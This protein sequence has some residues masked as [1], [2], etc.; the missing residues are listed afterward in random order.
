MTC[1]LEE[2][3][4][5]IVMHCAWKV[6]RG[7]SRLLVV[8]N[9]TDTVAR[10]LR[11]VA[12]FRKRGLQEL[13]VEVGTDEIRR[14]IPLHI[15]AEKLEE[16]LCKVIVKAHILTGDDAI[17]KIGTKHASLAFD[18]ENYLADFAES[19]TVT[20]ENFRKA[21]EYLIQVWAGVKSKPKSKT[22]DKLR[23]E[24]QLRAKIPKLIYVLPP[25]SSVI[26][27][28]IKE[29]FTLFGKFYVYM[30]SVLPTLPQI[31]PNMAG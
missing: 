1:D 6:D 19:D 7:S 29:H 27:G 2:A 21:E 23:V 17:S 18:P 11:Y 4:D 20:D 9:D 22:F 12:H 8:S 10:L 14:H 16:G 25:T 3:D 30:M 13:W 15:H 24:V 28:H 26:H 5:R 31:R